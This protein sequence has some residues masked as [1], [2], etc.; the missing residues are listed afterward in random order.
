MPFRFQKRAA[1][2]T[3]DTKS[4]SDTRQHQLAL[5]VRQHIVPR[6]NW[7]D[8]ADV[9]QV[10][11]RRG[12]QPVPCQMDTH[13]LWLWVCFSADN[14]A[15]ALQT[16]GEIAADVAFVPR[17]EQTHAVLDQKYWHC[18]AGES[19][20]CVHDTMALRC[21]VSNSCHCSQLTDTQ[22][23]T[24]AIL[25]VAAD[26]TQDAQLPPGSAPVHN[27]GEV[28]CRYATAKLKGWLT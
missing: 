13:Q 4:S 19:T 23:L 18:W 8:W 27:A 24:D 25:A 15:A 6:L 2:S 5:L 12:L 9:C 26:G 28:L 3:S 14:I 7:D 1:K 16:A 17:V 11:L 21:L 22:R 10:L 20:L